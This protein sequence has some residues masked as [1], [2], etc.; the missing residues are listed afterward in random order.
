MTTKLPQRTSLVGE[1]LLFASRHVSRWRREP[2]LPIQSVVF[3]TLLLIIYYVLIGE[4]MTRITGTDNLDGLVPMCALAGGLF[5]ALGAGFAIP[6]DRSTGLLS[7]LWTFPVHRASAL[8]GR[9]LAEAART[10]VAAALITAVGVALG[11]RFDGGWIAVI[12]FLLVPVLVVVVFATVV[13]TVALAAAGPELN[14]TFTWL[15]TGSIGL[16][17]GSAGVAPV[18]LFPSWLR[19]VI[20][21]QPMSPAIESMRALAAGD[22]ALWPLMLT[23][24]WALVFAAVFGPLAVRRY[25]LAAESG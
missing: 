25:R 8:I 17:F 23:F 24:G 13:L 16:V 9:L 12:P 1:S 10:L 3:P 22:S 2:L 19:P 4:S 21:F 7:R 14:S 18:E 15:A 11:L 6:F 5:G 20:Q